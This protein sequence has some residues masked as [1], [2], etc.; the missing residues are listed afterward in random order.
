MAAPKRAAAPAVVGVNF[1]DLGM[2]SGGNFVP[3][4]DYI[5]FFN[6]QNYQPKGK[7]GSTKG[8]SRLGVVVD[9][10]PFENPTEEGKHPQ[11]YSMGSK[12]DLSFAPNP[13][14]G[15]GVVPIPGAPA[16]GFNDS[17]NWALLLKSLYDSSLPQG[18]FTNDFTAIDGIWV[19]VTNVDEPSERAGFQTNTGDVANQPRKNNKIA[20]VTEIK[21]DGKPW[22]GGGGLPEA[23]KAAAPT[24]KAAP[25]PVS[26]PKPAAAPQATGL[27]DADVENG[28]IS[29]LSELFTAKPK[30]CPR[31]LARNETFKYAKKASGEDMASAIISNYF[32]PGKED[33]LAALLGSLGFAVN[34]NVIEPAA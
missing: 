7:D 6:V 25:K 3:D 13:E 12:A 29:A 16:T 20:I 4:G 33:Q 8:P 27:D 9:F 18:V 32:E 5:M 23:P 30:G 14:T 31:L 21:D 10:Y 19:H 22:E 24:P 2:Y 26:V 15:K 28:A 17:T 1:G 34:G 11:F